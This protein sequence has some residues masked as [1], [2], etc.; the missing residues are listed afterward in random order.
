ML[1]RPSSATPSPAI[2]RNSVVLPQPLGPSST[3]NSRSPIVRLALLTATKLPKRFVTFSILI[4][5]MLV[6][7]SGYLLICPHMLNR[8]FRIAKMKIT[9]GTN[10]KNPPANL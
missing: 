5:A 1:I 9:D 10:M 4:S 7:L 6:L 2:A 8:Y 3:M